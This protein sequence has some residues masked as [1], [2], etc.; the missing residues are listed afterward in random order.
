MDRKSGRTDVPTARTFP[1]ILINY[2]SSHSV[3]GEFPGMETG[4]ARQV[5]V[6]CGCQRLIALEM[7][8]YAREQLSPKASIAGA[9]FNK[10][11][12]RPVVVSQPSAGEEGLRLRG[13]S[14]LRAAL[15][16]HL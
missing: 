12:L 15:P 14:A 7:P 16:Q 3:V 11:L 5:P 10:R 6:R 4:I 8:S 13:V 9:S 1:I 2:G